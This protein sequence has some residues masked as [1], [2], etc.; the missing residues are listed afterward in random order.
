ME[1]FVFGYLSSIEILDSLGAT[2]EKT[3]APQGKQPEVLDGMRVWSDLVAPHHVRD[4]SLP[5]PIPLLPLPAHAIVKPGVK[6]RPT[7]SIVPHAWTCFNPIDDLIRLPGDERVS[8]V[9]PVELALVQL[10]STANRATI[11]DLANQVTGTYRVIRPAAIATYQRIPGAHVDLYPQGSTPQTC[12]AATAYDVPPLTTVDRIR[13]FTSAFPGA[14]G[15]RQLRRALPLLCDGLASPL[16]ERVFVLGFCSRRM[17]SF[18]L[19]KPLVNVPL[20][21]WGD[22]RRFIGGRRIVPDFY[23]KEKGLVLEVL[24]QRYHGR[25]GD[26]VET[27]LREKAYREMGIVC[28]TLTDVEVRDVVKFEAAM[29]ELA[30]LLEVRLPKETPTFLKQKDRLRSGILGGLCQA[31]S[32][33]APGN[34][35]S[36]Q[37]D[38]EYI[39]QLY[40]YVDA[41]MGA[42]SA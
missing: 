35:P 15:V 37:M 3:V 1:P 9:C 33:H 40:A 19:P 31:N 38:E 14:R 22:A 17:G 36:P 34:I 20:E 25:P 16:E 5:A 10:A 27:S 29:R 26:I 12:E 11:V 8:Y 28:L 23:W 39:N 42:R 24:G 13:S 18:D 4:D 6:T 30:R 32:G 41:D 7:A 21:P 2:A